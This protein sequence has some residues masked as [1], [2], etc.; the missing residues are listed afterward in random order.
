[1]PNPERLLIGAQRRKEQ[2]LDLEREAV[3][4]ARRQGWSWQR[5]AAQLGI[6][7][8]AT[9]KKYAAIAAVDQK[10]NA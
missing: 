2:A 10:E 7:Y 8:Q 9:M 3:L 4:E 1:M 6:S 5:I